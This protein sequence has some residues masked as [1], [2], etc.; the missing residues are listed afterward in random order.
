MKKAWAKFILTK[1]HVIT[2]FNDKELN[3]NEKPLNF[4]K[5]EKR[6]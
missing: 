6:T 1:S 5:N 2:L 3:I 4:N